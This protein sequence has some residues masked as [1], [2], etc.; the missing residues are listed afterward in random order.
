MLEISV[1]PIL[2]RIGIPALLIGGALGA[3]IAWHFLRRE[4]DEL[5]AEIER[6]QENIST[7]ARIEAEREAAFEAANARLARPL[8]HCLQRRDL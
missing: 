6:L 8:R 5:N 7:E 2:F 3:A 4:S 1:D